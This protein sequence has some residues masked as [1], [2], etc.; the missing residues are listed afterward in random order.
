MKKF[1]AVIA[2]IVWVSGCASQKAQQEAVPVM[3]EASAADCDAALRQAKTMAAD[4]VAGTFIHGQRT[5]N[6]DRDYSETLNEYSGGVVQKYQ[7]LE[8]RGNRPCTIKIQAWVEPGKKTVQLN[9]QSNRIGTTDINQRI[10]QITNDRKFLARQ[11]RDTDGFSVTLGKMSVSETKP[12]MVRLDMQVTAIRVPP[13]WVADL[14]GYIRVHSETTVYE[15]DSLAKTMAKLLTPWQK[16]KPHRTSAPEICFV[17]TGSEKINCYI[18]EDNLKIMQAL[19]S[20]RLDIQ[21][22]QN[23]AVVREERQMVAHLRLFS[24]QSFGR[25]YRASGQTLRA[26]FPVIEAAPMPIDAKMSFKGTGLPEDVTIQGRVHF[27]NLER[28]PLN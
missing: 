8:K 25:N 18:G 5:L 4:N 10:G 17:Q 22:I 2:F 12:G 24:D 28:F 15:Q 1:F 16:E 9:P 26:T 23:G 13:R 20:L 7:V 3:A 14:E 11:F 21:M 19:N 27:G 6:Q